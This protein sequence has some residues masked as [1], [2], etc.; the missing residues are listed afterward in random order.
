MD[1]NISNKIEQITSSKILSSSSVSGGCISN[2]Y[3]IT[4]DDK[5]NLFLKINF[6]HPSDM[7]RKEADG[8]KELAKPQVIKIP[9]V[10]AVEDSFIL[11]EFIEG[12]TKEKD[13]FENFGI[14]FAELH[15]F[16]SGSFGFYEDNY[17]GST[18]QINIPGEKEKNNWTS[19]YFNK[20]ILFQFKL[21]EKNGYA[22]DELKKGILFL[23]DNIEKILSGSEEPPSLLHGDLW[24]GNYMVNKNGKVSLIDPAVY[25]G[26]READ[27][28]MTKLFGGFSESFYASYNETY[29]LKDGYNY[30]ENIY[31]LY[32]VLN[33]L[34]LFGRGYYSQAISLIKSYN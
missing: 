14:S 23:E 30:R 32:H 25:Y 12:S 34:N 3:K 33:H 15:K 24:G 5:R 20:R 17:I 31:K 7:F 26:H 1:K 16:T 21:A 18:K 11:L 19:F 29:P 2:A 4:L 6:L 27:L 13:F 28:A 22:T 10:I 9:K 8:L